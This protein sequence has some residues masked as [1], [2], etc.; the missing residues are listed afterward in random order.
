[1]IM[2][3]TRLNCALHLVL[4]NHF[5]SML[6]PAWALACA[7]YFTRSLLSNGRSP[8]TFG[9]HNV[10][11][12]LCCWGF[13]FIACC[14]GW[15]LRAYGPEYANCGVVNP[16]VDLYLIDLWMFLAISSLIL[17]YGTIIFKMTK[18]LRDSRS[19]DASNRIKQSNAR[20]QR[21]IR[22]IGLY[23]LAY[24]VQWFGYG[25]LKLALVNVTKTDA[26]FVYLMFAVT[27]TN[28]GGCFNSLLYGQML[29]RQ[30]KRHRGKEV[31]KLA[32]HNSIDNQ[33]QTPAQSP[34]NESAIC[35]STK[36]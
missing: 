15:S 32:K 13:P 34:T 22:N 20:M 21:V 12:H 2:S 18:A 28:S 17:L 9:P 31:Q 29:W 23:P 3:C 14:I 24:L 33:I 8:P 30:I 6:K 36:L 25:L 10:Y 1:M 16:I 4:S 7:V 27:C 26:G 19:E 11:L 35:L 5:S